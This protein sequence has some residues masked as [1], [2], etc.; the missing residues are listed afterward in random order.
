[1]PLT[2]LSHFLIYVNDLQASKDFYT[3]VLG[4]HVGARPPFPFP[5]YWLYLGNTP[6]VHMA[7]AEVGTAQKDYLG[8][9]QKIEKNTGAVDHIAFN[10]T[11]LAEF[12]EHAS[13][14]DIE[15]THRSIPEDGSYQI[16]FRDPNGIKI[17]L[18]F[19]AEEANSLSQ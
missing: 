19:Q 14:C 16:F 9:K 7:S 8:E 13:S 2:N 12:L 15:L 3:N 1:M 5:G 6:C 11:N 17:E 10:A 4:M 18:T